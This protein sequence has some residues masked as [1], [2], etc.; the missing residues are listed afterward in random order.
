MQLH[1]H[2]RSVSILLAAACAVAIAACGSS[3]NR[4]TAAGRGGVAR[5]V[6]FADCMRSHGVSNFP[7]PTR[8]GGGI[9]LPQGS[10]PALEAAVRECGA[11]QP[12]GEGGPP[13]PTAAELH[14]ARAFAQCMRARGLSQFPDPLTTYGPGLTLG[15]GEYFP[16]SSSTD[17]QSPAVRQAAKACGLQVPTGPP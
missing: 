12:G 2:P 8:A 17:V 16:V 13:A 9:Q 11:L 15:R 10:S 4:D 7:D 3:S 14:A 1:C 5:G 6:E